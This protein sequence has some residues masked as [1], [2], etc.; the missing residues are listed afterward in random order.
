MLHAVTDYGSAIVDGDP[1]LLD[2]LVANLIE[3]AIR[4]N[5]DGGHLEVTTT[6]TPGGEVRLSV[7]NP[8]PLIPAE[9]VA[10]LFQPFQRLGADRIGGAQG[11]G[12]GLAVV[13]AIGVAHGAT[14]NA[15]ARTDGGLDVDINFPGP[16]GS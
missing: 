4:H 8:G 13:Q 15:A 7:S 6:T 10:R 9:Q 14:I 5:V 12:I 3:N 11:H 1:R 16:R 2:S